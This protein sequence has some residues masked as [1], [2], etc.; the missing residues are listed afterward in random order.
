MAG[1]AIL[2]AIQSGIAL[3]NLI[4]LGKQKR[5]NFGITP[6]QRASY[7]QAKVNAQYG[8]S[9]AQR[10]AFENTISSSQNA[11]YQKA[12]DIS[13]GQQNNA[14]SGILRANRLGAYNQF[15]SQDAA[16]KLQNQQYADRM[17]RDI[18]QQRNMATNQDI[19]NRI[20]TEDA[21]GG[22]LQSGLTNLASAGNFYA[23]TAQD[24]NPV[25][26]VRGTPGGTNPGGTN[27][28]SASQTGVYQGTL[29][30]HNPNPWSNPYKPP[31]SPLQ[32][33]TYKLPKFP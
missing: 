13:G 27:P 25:T 17:G 18:T 20:R 31:T 4:K 33:S 11:A 14:I 7:D 9:P 32:K 16:L 19:Q 29:G 8:Y 23:M 3:A 6:E 21:W 24:Y 1:T 2:G 28:S 12:V 26:G 15:A 30:Q 22:A 5:P 10:G